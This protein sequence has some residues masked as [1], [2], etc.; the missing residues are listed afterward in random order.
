MS[1]TAIRNPLA[2]ERVIELSPEDAASAAVTWLRRPNLFAGRALTAPTLE[3][4]SRWAAG[5]VAQRGQAFTP[6]VVRGLEVGHTVTPV[7]PSGGEPELVSTP[8]PEPEF[9]PLPPPPGLPFVQLQ[10]AAGQ[11]LSVSGE[12]VIVRELD[13]DFWSLPVVAPPAVFEGGGFGGG[14]VLQPRAIGMSVRDLLAAHPGALPRAGVLVLQPTLTERAQIDPNDPCDRCACGEHDG[15]NVSYEDWRYADGARLLW[16]AWPEDWAPAPPAGTQFRNRLAYTAFD[17][18]RALGDGDCMPWEQF[19]VPLALVGVDANFVPA[20]IDHAAVVRRGGRGRH[21]R[22]QLA[23][24]SVRLTA[25]PRLPALW[26]AQIEQ[27]AEHINALGDPSPS[28]QALSAQFDRLPPCGLLPRNAIDWTT[29][30]SDFFP[31]GMDLDAVPVP[32]EQL[33]LAIRESAGLAPLDVAVGERVRVL[34][35]VSQASYEPRLLVT[36]VID[37]E[38]E[39]TLQRFVIDR[40]DALA[41]RQSLRVKASF[42]LTD[43]RGPGKAPPVPAIGD[44]PLALEIETLDA[45]GPPP[46]EGGHRSQLREGEHTH[47]FAEAVTPV[48]ATTATPFYAWVYLDPEHPPRTLMLDF[49]SN[50]DGPDRSISAYWGEDGLIPREQNDRFRVKRLG[51]LPETG[52][53]VRLTVPLQAFD[54]GKLQING[55]GF[56]L[57][58]GRA[59]YGPLGQQVDGVDQIWFDSVPPSGSGVFGATLYGNEPFEVVSSNTLLAPFESDFGVSNTAPRGSP[60]NDV[61]TTMERLIAEVGKVGILSNTESAQLPKLGIEGFMTY[62]KQR[63]DRADDLVDYGFVKVQTD[64]YR[65][66]Q[67]VLDATDATRLAVSPALANIAKAET[68]V[69]SQQRI[70][71][72]ISRLRLN[73]PP[74]GDDNDEAASEGVPRSL[75]GTSSSGKRKIPADT[76]SAESSERMAAFT[77]T[78]SERIAPAATPA[79]SAAFASSPESAS[80]VPSFGS[81]ASAAPVFTPVFTPV[82]TPPIASGPSKTRTPVIS[83]PIR[84]SYTPIDVSNSAPLIGNVNLRTISLVERLRLPKAQEARDYST[85]TRHEAVLGLIRLA[86]QL[87][88]Q[89]GEM[90]GLFENIDVWGLAG[91]RF[92]DDGGD[93][94]KR[95]RP[96][97]DF[98]HPGTRGGLLKQ[99][100]APPSR[101]IADEGDMFS[102]TTDMADRT[103]ALFR[104]IEARI[105]SYRDVIAMCETARRS[106]VAD[107]SGIGVRER[108]YAE[109]LAEARHDVAV[110]RAL[111]AE[112]LARI[113][114]INARRADILAR[115]VRFVAYVRPRATDALSASVARPLDPGLLDAPAPACLQAHADVPEELD[116]MLAVLREAPAVW[117]VQGPRLLD[118]LDRVDL[119]LKTL[120]STQLRTQLAQQRLPS[121]RIAHSAL[122]MSQSLEA[123]DIA[124]QHALAAMGPQTFVS[125]MQATALPAIPAVLQAPSLQSARTTANAGLSATILKVQ[126]AQR[127]AIATARAPS[128]QLDFARLAAMTWQSVRAEAVRLVSLGDLIDGE[129]GQGPVA[130]NA[131]AF[132]DRFSHICGCL[133]AGFSSVLPSIRLD[134]AEILSQF[135]DAPDLH[136][137]SGLA[138]WPEIDYR[139]RRRLQGLV[140]WLFDQIH[141]QEPRARALVNDIVRMCLLLAS[142]AP[143]GR[144]IAGRLPRPV[145]ARP[146]LRIPLVALDPTRLRIGMQALIYRADRVVARAVVEDLGAGEASARVIHTEEASIE[147]DTGMRVQF[148]EANTVSLHAAANAALRMR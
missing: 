65:L 136:D 10:I 9:E 45:W 92:F 146:G 138:R 68:A 112:E 115:E 97:V 80:F 52:Q 128:L 53:W 47:G 90:P 5:H 34:V 8:A 118:R 42:L 116:D 111:I 17:R 86:D 72:Y 117:F 106:I 133:H 143:V 113:A 120:R 25:N 127:N 78:M 123:Q 137:L 32:V 29:R 132:F 88:A 51:D 4:R 144:I 16:Y 67:L 13:A 21:S 129:H 18:E 87:M 142:H 27:L 48:L 91:D 12:D 105:K 56:T 135:D 89:D 62:L 3:T 101:Q 139:D 2:G 126:A 124:A 46:G 148:A 36:E 39:A 93:P 94:S 60:P 19:G 83:P 140:D 125:P 38:F 103:I 141:T 98:I 95:R 50:L 40:A 108:A 1:T 110:T 84:A 81:A 102:D 70:S 15:G 26:Q 73:L 61:G 55:V 121:P 22:L 131:A 7:P 66:R 109:R 41:G 57:Y 99:L 6:G 31:S 14:G 82:V 33:D 114:A 145:T 30:R 77:P 79:F 63:A 59:A 74:A 147:L 104:Q 100:L 130:R 75:S 28:P 43:L 76:A 69:A 49:G 37:P 85:N 35:P 96:L 107:L 71:D 20:F 23:L 119:L 24:P 122:A 44:D 11:G 58:D 54:L 134:W 64:I